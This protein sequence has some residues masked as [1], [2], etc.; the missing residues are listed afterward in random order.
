MAEMAVRGRQES[1]PMSPRRATQGMLPAIVINGVL[2]FVLYQFLTGRGVAT[3][4]ALC[5]GSI[6][7]V[8]SI[9][10]EWV[11]TRRLAFISAVSLAFIA[12]SVATSLVSGDARFTLLKES[13]FTGLTGLLFLGSLFTRRPIMFVAGRQF[14]TQGDPERM[15]EWDGYWQFAGFRRTMRIM[16]AVW[17]VAYVIEALVRVVLVFALST[18]AFLIVSQL[19]VYS[20]TAALIWWTM[21]YGRRMQRQA[22]IRTQRVE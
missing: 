5:A 21:R 14:T 11:R 7:P 3:V 6:F 20:V 19:L 12:I 10:V 15:A 8:A 1:A 16:T 17:G 9:A 18:S 13:A 2:P 22:T 4:P